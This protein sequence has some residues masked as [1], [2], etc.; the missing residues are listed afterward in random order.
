MYV[1][2]AHL[3]GDELVIEEF[4]EGE[5]ASFFAL[6][7]GEKVVPLI[8]AQ[9]RRTGSSSD[10][11]HQLT[12]L[13]VLKGVIGSMLSQ[14]HKAAGDGDTGPNTGGMGT[15]S[16]APVVTDAVSRQT[17]DEIM[18]R[19]ARAMVAEGAPFKGTLFAG[20]MIK[21]GKVGRGCSVLRDWGVLLQPPGS[22]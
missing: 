13:E 6:V 2:Y 14:D 12:K 22:T 18:W 10:Q 21:D 7:D 9:V 3:P 20:L 19:T 11:L 4:L 1:F 16:P 15:Y 8:A 5:E 17:M